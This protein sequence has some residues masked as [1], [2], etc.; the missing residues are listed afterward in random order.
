MSRKKSTTPPTTPQGKSSAPNPG[1]PDATP[2][3]FLRWHSELLR[4]NKPITAIN[5]FK[6][7]QREL[8][9]G[10]MH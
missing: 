8:R 2:R 7:L 6:R 10:R 4:R 1:S 5:P 9:K 3:E